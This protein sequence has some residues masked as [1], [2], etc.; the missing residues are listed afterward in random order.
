ME[1]DLATWQKRRMTEVKEED[2]ASS[3]SAGEGETAMLPVEERNARVGLTPRN[4]D[5]LPLSS[6]PPQHA[7][8]APSSSPPGSS[9]PLARNPEPVVPR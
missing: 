4:S 1:G 9:R 8:T 2:D 5:E 3:V 6:P 7:A